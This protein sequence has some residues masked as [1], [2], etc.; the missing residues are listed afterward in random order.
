MRFKSFA[1]GGIY[2]HLFEPS[3]ETRARRLDVLQSARGSREVDTVDEAFGVI[4]RFVRVLRSICVLGYLL[5]YRDKP[6]HDHI[7]AQNIEMI[8]VI[9]GAR[10]YLRKIRKIAEHV[11]VRLVGLGKNVVHRYDVDGNASVEKRLRRLENGLVPRIIE[12]IGI[13]RRRDVGKHLAVYKHTA[14]NVLLRPEIVGIL[15]VPLF[16]FVDLFFTHWNF[17]RSTKCD[18]SLLFS[19]LPRAFYTDDYERYAGDDKRRRDDDKIPACG[20]GRMLNE[21]DLPL[22]LAY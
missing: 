7:A 15:S 2:R 10:G 16:G 20:I 14:K 18:I 12:I 9:D 6:A 8:A 4:D 17:L 21:G 19:I 11:Y 22:A 1:R 5:T 13:Y 3:Q